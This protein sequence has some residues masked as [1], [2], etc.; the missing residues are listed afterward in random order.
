MT[1]FRYFVPIFRWRNKLRS[2]INGLR[3]TMANWWWGWNLNSDLFRSS[4]CAFTRMRK[5]ENFSSPTEVWMSSVYK[6]RMASTKTGFKPLCKQPVCWFL[7]REDSDWGWDL[8]P[9]SGPPG[10]T[11]YLEGVQL[12]NKRTRS[13][14]AGSPLQGGRPSCPSWVFIH[15]S[16]T[17][18]TLSLCSLREEGEVLGRPDISLLWDLLHLTVTP[19]ASLNRVIFFFF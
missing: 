12:A 13:P 2:E 9:P 17:H 4:L 8:T 11:F 16:E 18:W 19:R 3:K 10:C 5:A 15:W 7:S 14:P 1:V 6:E